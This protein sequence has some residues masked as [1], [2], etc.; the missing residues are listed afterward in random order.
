MSSALWTLGGAL[1]AGAVAFYLYLHGL[2][3]LFTPLSIVFIIILSVIIWK[4]ETQKDKAR[5]ARLYAE[6]ILRHPQEKP[7]IIEYGAA[8]FIAAIISRDDNTVVTA[9]EDCVKDH[10]AYFNNHRAEY[11]ELGIESIENIEK[12]ELCWMNMIEQLTAHHYAVVIDW[13][14]ETE[15]ILYNLNFIAKKLRLPLDMEKLEISHERIWN[16]ARWNDDDEPATR[17]A[18]CEISTVLKSKGYALGDIDDGSD[19]YI[20]FLTNEDQGIKETLVKLANKYGRRISFNF[21]RQR[22]NLSMPF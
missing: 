2:F 14:T 15:D 6:G 5:I 1:L 21:R 12:D 17:D 3:Y 11:T 9:V 13:K 19:S 22:G 20:L 16:H 10:I 4:R 8:T 7:A 18:L